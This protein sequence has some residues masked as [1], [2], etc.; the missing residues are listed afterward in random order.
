MFPNSTLPNCEVILLDCTLSVWI[1]NLLT[2]QCYFS[3]LPNCQVY[4]TRW[5]ARKRFNLP[6]KLKISEL[7]EVWMFFL[8]YFRWA[9]ENHTAPVISVFSTGGLGLLPRFFPPLSLHCFFF[10]FDFMDLWSLRGA[11]SNLKFTPKF[12][13]ENNEWISLQISCF[14]QIHFCEWCALESS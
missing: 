9:P 2:P 8:I 13:F 11:L 7:S 3:I 5:T 1:H 12:I 14:F 6:I 10:F 4:S